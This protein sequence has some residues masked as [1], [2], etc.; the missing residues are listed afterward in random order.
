MKAWLA[1]GMMLGLASPACAEGPFGNFA[2]SRSGGGSVT[3]VSTGVSES[4]RCH[5]RG[6]PDGDG[7]ELA[8]SCKSANAPI[9]LSC[10]LSA[11]G[12]NVS[13]TC[14][15]SVNGVSIR[16]SGRLDG[17]AISGTGTTPFSSARITFEPH[18][19][20]MAS[21][22]ARRIRNLYVHF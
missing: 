19:I 22:N 9:D 10:S 11:H 1:L 8:V 3:P 7:L 6:S 21:S 15:E 2:G 14:Y 20:S 13:G 4:T 12:R 18:R 17:D 5:Q 16:F